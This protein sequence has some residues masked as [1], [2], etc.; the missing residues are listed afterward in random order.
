MRSALFSM[1]SLYTRYVLQPI[2]TVL[3]S[4]SFDQ[5]LDSTLYD[6]DLAGLNKELSKLCANA[7]YP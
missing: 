4:K 5:D 7:T 2:Y 1:P 6:A 3:N